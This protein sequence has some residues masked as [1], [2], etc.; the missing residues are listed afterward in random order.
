M[1]ERVLHVCLIVVAG[2][3]TYLAASMAGFLPIDDV[4]MIAS[5][6]SAPV[7]YKTL[8]LS[9]ANEYYRPLIVISYAANAA[10]WGLGPGSFHVF[11]IVIHIANS[12]LVYWLAVLLLAE[13]E[14]RG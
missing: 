7:T 2:V 8:F 9:G 1:K 3:L 14:R 5:V 11:N 6:S 4:G 13:K 12:L 10:F